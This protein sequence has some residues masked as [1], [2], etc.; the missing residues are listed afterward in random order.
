MSNT[1]VLLFTHSI[2]E[3]AKQKCFIQNANSKRNQLVAKK[4]IQSIESKIVRSNIPYFI[5][6]TDKQRGASFGERLGNAI[7]D[8][9]S[10]GYEKVIVVGNDCPDISSGNFNEALK[11]L[12]INDLII[13][14]TNK[15]GTYLIGLS[16]KIYDRKSFQ[17]LPWQTK[18]L[19]NG[20]FKYAESLKA[21]FYATTLK[22]EINTTDDLAVYIKKERN[23]TFAKWIISL[24]SK[25][26]VG[27]NLRSSCK[28]IELIRYFFRLTSPPQLT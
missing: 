28:R 19:L 6:S 12:S 24:I 1:A 17:L 21:S 27:I 23:S 15:G 26:V 8:V 5:I 25:P 2:E 18:Y 7:E 14:P 4:L 3:E 20:L 22:Q 13:G 10:E 11:Q 16:K 9:F